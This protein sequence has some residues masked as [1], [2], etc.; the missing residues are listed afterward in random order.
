MWLNPFPIIWRSEPARI[1]LPASGAAALAS[2]RERLHGTSWRSW[3]SEGVRGS[4]GDDS[5]RVRRY[6][7]FSR[8]D[9]WGPVL[10]AR[11]LYDG[12]TARLVGIYRSAW[13]VRVFHTFWFGLMLLL[14][15]LFLVA[16]WFNS[17]EGKLLDAAIAALAPATL[18]FIGRIGLAHKPRQWEAD[19]DYLVRLFTGSAPAGGR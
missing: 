10:E 2:A 16:A 3:F 9:N 8:R 15:P 5:V 12:R 7:P 17:R 13:F 14:I 18:F 19:K 11:L 4:I 1:E 6:R